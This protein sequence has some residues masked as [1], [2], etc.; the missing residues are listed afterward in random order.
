MMGY[1]SLLKTVIVMISWKWKAAANV[2]ND[3]Q[4]ALEEYTFNAN[5]DV[6][7]DAIAI[8]VYWQKKTAL[9]N[10]CLNKFCLHS[11]LLNPTVTHSWKQIVSNHCKRKKEHIVGASSEPFYINKNL[12]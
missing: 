7:N 1:E 5:Q 9:E 12:A 11:R 2:E 6:Y 4:Q 10:T 3:I 8:A